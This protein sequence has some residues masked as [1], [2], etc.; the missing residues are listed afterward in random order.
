M[1]NKRFQNTQDDGALTRKRRE[2]LKAHPM[3]PREAA[4]FL[5]E[6]HTTA[7]ENRF[8]FDIHWSTPDFAKVDGDLYWEAWRVLREVSGLAD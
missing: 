8:G 4:R 7:D 5:C 1:P 2:N 6:V 3:S